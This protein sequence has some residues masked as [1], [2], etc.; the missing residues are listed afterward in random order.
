VL[1]VIIKLELQYTNKIKN[2]GA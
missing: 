2:C 1:Y